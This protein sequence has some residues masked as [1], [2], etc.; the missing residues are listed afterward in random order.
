MPQP[1]ARVGDM[2]VCPMITVLV[3]HVGGPII[4]PGYPKVLIAGMPAA[5]WATCAPAWD[6]RMSSSW[7]I[8]PCWSADNPCAHGGS[9][10][11]RRR[12]RHGRSHGHRR[13]SVSQSRRSSL[14][15]TNRP[16]IPFERQ[17]DPTSSRMCGAAALCMV[18]RSFGING[19]QA[20]LAGKLTSPPPDS[21][22]GAVISWRKTPWP[23]GSA[24][25]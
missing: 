17:S 19:S 16:D 7:A 12:H 10:G 3:P 23:T 25:S 11:A 13:M 21:G 8:P 24:R 18:Y 1:A 4:P 2:H 14:P 6:R 9:N 5:P 20:E 22:R 15:E